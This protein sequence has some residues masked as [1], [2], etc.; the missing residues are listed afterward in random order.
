MPY[1]TAR[2][3]LHRALMFTL[4]ERT[5]LN[6]CYRCGKEMTV[7]NFSVDHIKNW[8]SSGPIQGS[9]LFFDL[10]NIDFSHAECNILAQHGKTK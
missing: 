8:E 3:R 9:K 2:S 5:D 7:D 6:Q 10:D 1:S 4:L